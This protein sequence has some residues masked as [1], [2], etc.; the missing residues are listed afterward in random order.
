MSATIATAAGT[1]KA[2]QEIWGEMKDSSW[3]GIQEMYE[4]GEISEEQIKTFIAIRNLSDEEWSQIKKDYLEGNIKK[5]EFEHIKQIREMPDDWTTLENGIKGIFYGVGT[6]VWEGIQ[7]YAG[8]KLAGWTLKAGSKV[9]TSA[10]RVGADTAFNAMDTPYRTLLDSLATGNTLEEAWATRGGWQSMLTDVGIGLISSTGGEVLD[11]L[12]ST[13]YISSSIKEEKYT[14]NIDKNINKDAQKM[15]KD[16]TSGISMSKKI[17]EELENILKDEDYIIGIHCSGDAQLIDPNSIMK[18]G[19]YLTGDLSSGVRN[20]VV[21]L[22]N[23]INFLEKRN[24]FQDIIMLSKYIESSAGYKTHGNPGNAIIVKIPKADFDNLSKLTYN[25]GINDVLKSEYILG[26]VPTEYDSKRNVIF[27]DLIYNNKQELDV[28]EVLNKI[29]ENIESI[30]AIFNSRGIDGETETKIIS[31]MLDDYQNGKLDIPELNEKNIIY[32]IT[33]RVENLATNNIPEIEAMKYNLD[34]PVPLINPNY[35]TKENI[36]KAKEL[37]ENFFQGDRKKYLDDSKIQEAFEGVVVLET[38]EEF[39]QTLEAYGMKEGEAAAFNSY[40]I[41]IFDCD[42]S[43]GTCIHEI[44]HSLGN[45]YG[46]ISEEAYGMKVVDLHKGINEAFT[47]HIANRILGNTNQSGYMLNAYALNEI[48][49]VMEKKGAMKDI[50][51]RTYFGTE[52]GDKTLFKDIA[53]SF[54]ENGFYE[55]L[56]YHMTR[57]IDENLS[58]NERQ[59]AQQIVI[60]LTEYFKDVCK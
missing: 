60:N 19:L 11:E 1:G 37:Y 30:D 43:T 20:G 38:K 23:N 39:I 5:E 9:A 40:G 58:F 27:K 29:N 25:N 36:I 55:S 14:F 48:L 41:S 45:V 3:E 57:A 16:M 17:G 52:Y 2:T 28:D 10:I 15:F 42:N 59:A 24:T 56:A 50:D 34:N 18:E 4:K 31:K 54:A 7:Y 13:K 32:E 26:Y 8:G 47:D 22:A 21:D 53:N 12:I 35:S 6:G 33:N 49:E 44:N 51:L 46:S